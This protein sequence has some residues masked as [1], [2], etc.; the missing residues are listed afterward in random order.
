MVTCQ[1]FFQRSTPASQSTASSAIRSSA[2]GRIELEKRQELDTILAPALAPSSMSLLSLQ[3]ASACGRLWLVKLLL[4]SG[5]QLE[6][7]D[8][9]SATTPEAQAEANSVE[10]GSAAFTHTPIPLPEPTADEVHA[11]LSSLQHAALNG[12]LHV[13]QYL[14]EHCSLK[15]AALH[16]ATPHDGLLLIHL[17]AM[18]GWL[19]IVRW[20]CSDLHASVETPTHTKHALTPLMCA[21][22]AGWTDIV[23]YLVE[24]QHAKLDTVSQQDDGWT[25]L[26]YVAAGGHVDTA[27]YLIEHCNVSPVQRTVSLGLTPLHIAARS[28]KVTLCCY[29]ISEAKADPQLLAFNGCSALL[30]CLSRGC[31]QVL[32]YLLTQKQQVG[33]LQ[34]SEVRELLAIARE[35]RSNKCVAVCEQWLARLPPLDDAPD[36]D[37]PEM[38]VAVEQP[39]AFGQSSVELQRL[40]KVSSPTDVDVSQRNSVSYSVQQRTRD[41]LHT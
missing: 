21:A 27:A 18:R 30:I 19:P 41:E 24:E 28:G 36:L 20:L 8:L 31:A 6:Q 29:L 17:C 37:L 10:A 35:R 33:L 39:S 34:R 26:H 38:S 1:T 12:H 5:A 11:S 4:K 2:Q 40:D 15:H 7:T 9:P 3:S 32:Q 13:C 22:A 16:S 25:A 23:R 14:V